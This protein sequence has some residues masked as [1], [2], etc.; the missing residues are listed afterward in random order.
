MTTTP[1]PVV[2]PWWSAPV[3]W[4]LRCWAAS[5]RVDR[6]GS[7]PL[8]AA[9]QGGG[10]V[11]ACWHGELVAQMLAHKDLGIVVMVSQSRDG[12]LLAVLLEGLG[13][14]CIRGS[15]SRGA[16]AAV[17][18]SRRAITEDGASV[19]IAVDGPRGPRHVAGPGAA[20][21]G[22][23]SA[24]PV[25]AVRANTRA[26][27]RLPT[28]DAMEVPMPFTRVRVTSSIV[29]ESGLVQDVLGD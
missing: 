15:T 1:S 13:Y 18:A 3:V 5:L 12:A 26:C 28:W 24:C 22:R 9:M 4:L 20:A 23:L 16:I 7:G 21:I 11:L 10:A 17:R 6:R 27:L 29:G 25:V 2:R 14:R 8:T 19:A